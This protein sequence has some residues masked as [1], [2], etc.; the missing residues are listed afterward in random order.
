MMKSIAP[1]IAAI[2]LAALTATA[3]AGTV[4][5]PSEN[6]AATV[7]IPASWKPEDIENG[8][9]CESP[10]QVATVF[11]EVTSAKGVE[12]LIDENV[13]WL[14]KEQRVD[15]DPAT[16]KSK[17]FEAGG[18]TWNRI[19]WDGKSKEWGPSVV[20][21]MFTKL[22]NGKVLTITYWITKKNKEKHD[23]TLEKM[24]SSVKAIKKETAF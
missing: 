3:S 13:D 17:D 16:Q 21:L 18:L 14:T 24:L 11:F 8:V 20:G 23:A 10:D 9:Q 12:A 5:I 6:P 15:I 2:L 1:S 19:S 22:S 7:E 4:K